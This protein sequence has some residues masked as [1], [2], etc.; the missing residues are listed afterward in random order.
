MVSACAA[1]SCT[2]T[3][4]ARLDSVYDGEGHR[5]RL[6]ETPAGQNPVPTI[7]DF[8]YEGDKVVR[9]VATT[10]TTV[11]TRTFTVDEAGAIVKMALA[12]TGGSTD[13]G[14]YLVAWNG[15]GDAVELSRID[16][17][18]G[19]LTPANRFTYT[20]WGTPSLQPVGTFGDLGFRYRYVGQF[21]VQWDNTTDV[22]AELLYMHARH[23]APEFG[24]FLQPDPSAAEANLYSYAENNP[25]TLNDCTGLYTRECAVIAVRMMIA[26]LQMINRWIAIRENKGFNGEP[27]PMAGPPGKT[28]V[29]THQEK[30]REWQRNAMRY[31]NE[32]NN[33]CTGG[34]GPRLPP[35]LLDSLRRWTAEPTPSPVKKPPYLRPKIRVPVPFWM[36]LLWPFQ[37]PP[38]FYPSGCGGGP[39][40]A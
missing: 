3:G 20:T 39:T 33:K 7:T 22:P 28:T 23:Y 40:V 15:H 30:F 5:I 31:R 27:L 16:P 36:Y 35:G 34:N 8:T 13:D 6:V 11:R 9:E 12:T 18:T 24:R 37:V 26:Q 25:A 2:G 29:A 19:L 10:G 21:D 38:C 1:G 14:T 4:F 17:G 32:W